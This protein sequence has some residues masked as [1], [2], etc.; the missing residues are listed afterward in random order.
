MVLP[1][2]ELNVEIHHI[3][4]H[5]GKIVVKVVTTNER[6]EKDLEGSAEVAQVTTVYVFTGQG[7]G[8]ST[9]FYNS[10]PAARDV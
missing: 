4:V 5:D 9:N 2:D 7:A 8:M 6:G 10:S 1:S 3:S